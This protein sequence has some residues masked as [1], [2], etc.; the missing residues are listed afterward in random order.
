MKKSIC[1]GCVLLAVLSVPAW[2][3][4][5]TE[6][7]S[8]SFSSIGAEISHDARQAGSE[9]ASGAKHAGHAIASGATSFG[10]SVVK[11]GKKVGHYIQDG[12]HAVGTG[13]KDGVKSAKKAVSTEQPPAPIESGSQQH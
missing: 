8:P 3:A 7:S 2:A 4:A 10:H 5:T 1:S 6:A 13:V 11:G 12:A 9:V